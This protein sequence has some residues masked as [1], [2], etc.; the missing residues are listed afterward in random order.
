LAKSGSFGFAK[1]W[2]AG[3]AKPNVPLAGWLKLF[4]K[5]AGGE[6]IKNT[7]S[8]MSVGLLVVRLKYGLYVVQLSK[9]F[10]L[11]LMFN[12]YSSVQWLHCR[13]TLAGN[14]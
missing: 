5:N 7:G 2:L 8:A 11:M 1:G 3:G 13:F 6:K 10:V 14:L 12:F 9:W 4:L